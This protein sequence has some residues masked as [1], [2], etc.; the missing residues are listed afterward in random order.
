MKVYVCDNVR[1]DK[2]CPESEM[3]TLKGYTGNA[4]GIL[5]PDRFQEK[6]FCNSD[7]FEVWLSN[8]AKICKLCKKGTKS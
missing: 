1:C 3:V 2:N 6:H 5:L 4:G 8:E 7:C